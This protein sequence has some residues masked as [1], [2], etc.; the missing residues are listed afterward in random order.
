[1]LRDQLV[2]S[3]RE[4]LELQL[5]HEQDLVN[6]RQDNEAKKTA[7]LSTEREIKSLKKF[8]LSTV[9]S[10]IL[11]CGGILRILTKIIANKNCSRNF[12]VRR[13]LISHILPPEQALCQLLRIRYRFNGSTF[14]RPRTEIIIIKY[15]AVACSEVNFPY[16]FA[17]RV[18][19]LSKAYPV[20]N[21]YLTDDTRLT[22][23]L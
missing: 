8:V 21:F 4:K 7:A 22:S 15:L 2:K 12:P 10:S 5:K 17:Y 13:Q 16:K 18:S 14:H 19:Y 11:G 1:V 6:L 20:G 23:I 9:G 3:E